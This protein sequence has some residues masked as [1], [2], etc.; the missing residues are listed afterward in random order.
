MNPNLPGVVVTGAS[1]F[2]GRNFLASAAG[3]Y[4]LFCLA[5]R[6][7]RDAGIPDYDNLHWTQV[8]ISRWETMRNV[9]NC[10]LTHGGAD[11]VVH[12]AGY[13][14][15]HNMDNPEYD[16]TNV[17]GTRNVLKLARQI[18]TARF[19]FAS[20]LAACEFPPVPPFYS[21]ANQNQRLEPF[22]RLGLARSEFVTCKEARPPS[23]PD[24]LS[25][26]PCESD[27]E[28]GNPGTLSARFRP[29]PWRR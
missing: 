4:R 20:S 12:L 1:G 18:G 3:R 25:P 11:Y 22:G 9:V 6:S 19:I 26:A 29:C 8:D 5:R 23:F 10:I 7:R 2:I 16:R 27:F 17:L 13:Y 14:D 24:S 15:F 21:S 28:G